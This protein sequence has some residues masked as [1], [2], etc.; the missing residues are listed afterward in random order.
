MDV[1]TRY[2]LR[3]LAQA[4]RDPKNSNESVAYF[5]ASGEVVIVF[6][7]T[8]LVALTSVILIVS[9]KHNTRIMKLFYYALRLELVAVVYWRSRWGTHWQ[10]TRFKAITTIVPLLSTSI[11]RKIVKSYFGRNLWFWFHWGLHVPSLQRSYSCCK[12]E[13]SRPPRQSSTLR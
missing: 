5:K 12:R 7:G 3:R 11:R 1:S 8:P 4:R 13:V 9:F 6:L 2:F 10:I